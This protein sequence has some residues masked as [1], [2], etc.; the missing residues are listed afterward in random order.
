MFS[1]LVILILILFFPYNTDP[2][3]FSPDGVFGPEAQ[4]NDVYQEVAMPIV[5]SALSGFNGTIFVY[6]Q[7]SS[8]KC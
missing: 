7:T 3:S 4:N 8:G 1:C 5:E 6:G 2:F